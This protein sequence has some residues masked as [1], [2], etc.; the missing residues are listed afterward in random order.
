MSPVRRLATPETAYAGLLV[1]LVLLLALPALTRLPLLDAYLLFVIATVV[2]VRVAPA[3]P[4][5]W[6]G[7]RAARR[8]VVLLLL[9]ACAV[10]MI[11]APQV[12]SQSVLLVFVVIVL[13]N[14]A[15]G[16]ATERVSTAPAS[17]VDERE[18]ALRNNAHRTAYL[19][20]GVT[21]ATLL[22]AGTLNLAIASWL[23]E[24]G[25]VFVLF[26][27]TLFL[28]AMIIAWRSPDSIVTDAPVRRSLLSASA[29]V[30]TAASLVIPF[31]FTAVLVLAP[32]QVASSVKDRSGPA[33]STCREFQAT[34]TVGL[35]VEAQLPLHAVVCWDGARAYELWGLNRSDCRLWSNTFA[36][37]EPVRCSD[38]TDANGTLRFAYEVDVRPSLLPMLRRRIAMHLSVSRTG[39]VL[40]FP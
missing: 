10:L 13:A 7:R 1:L 11:P 5:V 15:L 35:V 20:L 34:Q 6:L 37:V 21:V 39:Q 9:A 25:G 3:T 17:A 40:Q 30:M 32:A 19:L 12:L 26:E 33:G 24:S 27:L 14:V 2:V 8:A 18:E 4:G 22:V 16:K 36:I 29:A 38:V 31:L 28:P 23:T